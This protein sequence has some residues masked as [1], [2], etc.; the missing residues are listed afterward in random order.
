MPAFAPA[1]K[2]WQEDGYTRVS[3]VT[4]YGWLYFPAASASDL[5]V[6]PTSDEEFSP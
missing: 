2:G 1:S 6:R 3:Q 4:T 5:A